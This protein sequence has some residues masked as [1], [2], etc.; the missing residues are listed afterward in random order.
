MGLWRFILSVSVSEEIAEKAYGDRRGDKKG[1]NKKRVRMMTKLADFEQKNARMLREAKG[2]YRGD[3]IGIQLL[4][5]LI[6]GTAAYLLCLG[7]WAC[8][9][10][11][12]VMEHLNTMDIR[13]IVMG[14]AVSYGIAMFVF[15]LLTYILASVRFYR[16]GRK[17]Q[18]YR[19]MLECLELEYEDGTMKDHGDKGGRGR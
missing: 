4:K 14:I 10:M 5:N 6:R 16:D 1:M 9:R 3:Y 13:E 8:W 15:L 18:T 11:D 7:L 19:N 2:Y 17:L 12:Y